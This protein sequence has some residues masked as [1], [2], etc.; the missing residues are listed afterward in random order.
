MTLT[1]IKP[2]LCWQCGYHQNAMQGLP[3]QVR[4]APCDGDLS[5]CRK[6]GAI[7]LYQADGWR[8]PTKAELVGLPLQVRQK[9]VV[10]MVMQRTGI[11]LGDL[12]TEQPEGH[13]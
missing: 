7:A 12:G 11:G 13:A 9:L 2:C 5:L 8:A 4:R 1:P 6:C 3:N 10:A